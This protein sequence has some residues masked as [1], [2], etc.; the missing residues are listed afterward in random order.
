VAPD[1]AELVRGWAEEFL[2]RN[3]RSQTPNPNTVVVT[4]RELSQLRGAIAEHSK[5]K[6]G[7]ALRVECEFKPSIKEPPPTGPRSQYLAR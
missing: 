3:G 4:V 5:D 1:V 6:Y 7:K 2:R